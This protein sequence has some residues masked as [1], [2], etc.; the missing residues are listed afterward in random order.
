MPPILF[1]IDDFPFL[2]R[3][4]Q[5]TATCGSTTLPSDAIA[6]VGNASATC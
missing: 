6:S 4:A 2:V 1:L 5:I 3:L